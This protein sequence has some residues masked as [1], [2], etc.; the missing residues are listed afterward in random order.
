[1]ANGDRAVCCKQHQCDVYF[2]MEHSDGQTLKGTVIVVNPDLGYTHT[3]Y[4]EC[5]AD[6]FTPGTCQNITA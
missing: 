1:M 6:L 2:G 4:F 5:A 3:L